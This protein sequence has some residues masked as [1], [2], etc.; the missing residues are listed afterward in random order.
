M[1]TR[2]LP[3]YSPPLRLVVALTMLA[4]IP[5]AAQT[6]T[7]INPVSGDIDS[8]LRLAALGLEEPKDQGAA[9]VGL[10]EAALTRNNLKAALNEIKGFRDDFWRARALLLIADHQY[11]N[12][13]LSS[14]RENLQLAARGIRT[15]VPL[16]DNGEIFHTLVKRQAEI[17]DLAGALSTAKQVPDEVDRVRAMVEASIG[18]IESTDGLASAAVVKALT[19]A[20]TEVIKIDGRQSEV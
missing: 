9:L 5:A 7:I 19:D 16:R 4:A 14:A 1:W 12:G 8:A 17:G 2:F 11:K 10:V 20:Y 13:Q 15:N 18:H 6:L 3:V